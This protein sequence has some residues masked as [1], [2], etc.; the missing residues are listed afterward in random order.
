MLKKYWK[1]LVAAAFFA[2]AGVC[3]SQ[4]EPGSIQNEAALA[5]ECQEMELLEQEAREGAAG[6]SGAED[7][8]RGAAA[9]QSG[10]ISDVTGQIAQKGAAASAGGA[11]SYA[12]S[13][14]NGESDSAASEKDSTE[15][16]AAGGSRYTAE[17]TASICFVHVCGEV[18]KPG[19]YEL[20]EGS[21][22]FE[23][24]EQAGGF[25]EEAAQDFL[26]LAAQVCDG[27]KVMVPDMEEAAALLEA[28]ANGLELPQKAGDV[29]ADKQGQSRVNLNTATKEEFM[30]LKGIG[31]SRAED[32]IRYRE[33]SGGFRSIEDIMKVPGIKDAGFQKIKDR[34][35]V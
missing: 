7:G 21:R 6:R 35:T 2:V 22:I 30:T 12:G 3:Y 31:E 19:V 9:V 15:M 26:N 27:M 10:L 24:I 25:T 29:P 18:H 17:E 28:G 8:Q 14:D 16:Q 4:M 23:A 11:D 5:L 1:M 20:Q 32:I 34:I 33:E 13:T